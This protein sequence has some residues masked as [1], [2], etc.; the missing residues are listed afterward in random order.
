VELR[1]HIS[2]PGQ[3]I[4]LE[5]LK[6]ETSSL[7]NF[8]KTDFSFIFSL[9]VFTITDKAFYLPAI[10]HEFIEKAVFTPLF[11]TYLQFCPS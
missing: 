11:F 10:L 8:N 9:L 3:H 5:Y 2:V 6:P 7:I 4:L 1:Y